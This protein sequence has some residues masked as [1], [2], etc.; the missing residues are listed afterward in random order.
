MV[1]GMQERGGNGPAARRLFDAHTD[2]V[3]DLGHAKA[4]EL[5]NY[6]MEQQ[7][8]YSLPV[9]G[10]ENSSLEANKGQP[11]GPPSWYNSAGM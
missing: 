1:V 6:R 10:Q 11:D 8:K 3:G 9:G 5:S 7:Q 4:A 2:A